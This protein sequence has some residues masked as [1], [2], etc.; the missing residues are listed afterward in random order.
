MSLFKRFKDWF[1][2][3]DDTDDI[4]VLE[5]PLT[6]KKD[7]TVE[8]VVKTEPLTVKPKK[9]KQEKSNRETK[10]SLEK[11]TKVQIDELA[12]ERFGV[13]LDRR[14]R[15]ETMISEFMKEQRKAK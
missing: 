12:A 5:K 11:M 10:A 1:N 15:K 13:Q 6:T 2:G 4:L 9:K 7:A 14:N 8:T 3:G